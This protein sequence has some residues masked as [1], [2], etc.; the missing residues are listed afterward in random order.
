M[1]CSGSTG[2][3]YYLYDKSKV[4]WVNSGA[5]TLFRMLVL[6]ISLTTIILCGKMFERKIEKEKQS[7][8]NNAIKLR[9]LNHKNRTILVSVLK[10]VVLFATYLLFLF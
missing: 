5:G 7:E 6:H 9:N 3:S 2:T 8:I 1:S 10:K 4:T